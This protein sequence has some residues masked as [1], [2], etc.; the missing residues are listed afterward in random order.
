MPTPPKFY[1]VKLMGR[2]TDGWT[3]GQMGGRTDGWMDGKADRHREGPP[4]A[5]TPAP[6]LAGR[7]ARRWQRAAGGVMRLGHSPWGD[8]VVGAAGRGTAPGH[9]PSWAG[10]RVPFSPG[11]R[12]WRSSKRHEA[13]QKAT[14]QSADTEPARG[15]DMAGAW[16]DP[17]FKSLGFM[18]SALRW[19]KQTT[20]KHG[21]TWAERRKPQERTTGKRWR[22]RCLTEAQDAFG[23][24]AGGRHVAGPESPSAVRRW[25]PEGAGGGRQGW[26]EANIWWKK[27]IQLWVADTQ[28]NI[29]AHTHT[30]THT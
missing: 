4:A 25:W 22:R 24:L 11:R 30:Y 12:F 26:K 19:L 13:R 21:V 10:H 15:P 3:H 20:H 14:A 29:D 16:A 6:V 7:L 9:P 28:C 1:P 5:A 27:E 18:H 23:R 2:W 17:E 8:R